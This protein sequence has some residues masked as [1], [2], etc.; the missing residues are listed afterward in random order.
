LKTFIRPTKSKFN[1][2]NN[3]DKTLVDYGEDFKDNYV[4][5]PQGLTWY[6]FGCYLIARVKQLVITIFELI[7]LG[8]TVY[9]IS[10]KLYDMTYEIF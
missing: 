5:G 2:F 1:F 7:L 6:S 8:I 4:L 3:L 10:K 9:L